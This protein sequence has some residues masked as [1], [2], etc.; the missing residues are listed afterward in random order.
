MSASAYAAGKTLA[1]TVHNTGFLL[2][3]MGADCHPLQFLRELT[4]NAIEAI[5]RVQTKK[6]HIVWDVEWNRYDL[7]DG[8]PYKLCI[9]D[10]GDGMTGEEMVRYINRLSSSL[11]IQAI[12]GN[13]GVGAKIA[14]A[15]KNHAGLVYLSWKGGSGAMVH[16][17]R[18]PETGQYGLRH[19]E[20]LDGS[21]GH[22]APVEDALKPEMIGD[23]G[24]MIV[25]LGN[26]E[27]IDDTM[28]APEGSPSPSRWIAKYLNTRY[29]RLPPGI[30]VRAREGWEYE[31]SDKD[32][33]LLRRITGQEEYL[34]QHSSAVG[35]VEL[36]N[37]SA[38]WWIL[39]DDAALT[40]NSGFVE[41]SGH[42][43]A[44]YRDE[45]YDAAT[46]RSATALLQR[47]GVLF[48]Q[49]RVV[50]YVE[51]SSFEKHVVT[52]N[53]VRTNLLLD[54]LPLPWTDWAAEFREAMPAEIE[55]MMEEVSQGSTGVD[56]AQS[57]RDR[58]KDI[59]DL[60]NVSRYKP[61]QG[62]SL[63]IDDSRR[64]RGG[65][66]R[67]RNSQM[68]DGIGK[69]GNPGGTAGSVYSIFQKRDGVPG[70]SVRADVFPEIKW[71]SVEDGT[72]TPGDLEDRAARFLED[73][74][75]IFI[76]AD[77]RVFSDMVQRW[78]KEYR[79]KPGVREVV[80]D[81]VRSWFGTALVE[82][83]IGLQALKD[84]KEWT[85]EDVERALSE[86]GLTAAVMS[87]YHVNNQVKR[88][89]GTKLGK[90]Q[91]A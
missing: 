29:F 24:T 47:F 60:F 3:K 67:N 84:S 87:R 12:D 59:L 86:E 10:D 66:A 58:L 16:L 27:L 36:S 46:G 25:L 77:F 18:D 73:Q 19:F 61:S 83:V 13:F 7:T 69:P 4:Q 33:N 90:L 81:S 45:L 41:S 34:K 23:H 89:L 55:A 49:R 14:A 37:A 35:A 70:R 15:T 53:T 38:R 71:V 79:G 63:F 26:D 32:R 30:D 6:G 88:E 11:S 78:V 64:T 75:L 57:I 82:T 85:V 9:I 62:G 44:L 22:F 21:F 43:A 42:V 17:W 8:G 68:R 48:G 54:H 50:I 51:P 2:D 20:R 72:R 52:T 40:Q 80:R 91:T 5:G 56:H 65:A 76:N 39:K 31:R 74:N 28:K 1:L